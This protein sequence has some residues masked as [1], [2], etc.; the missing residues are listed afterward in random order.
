MKKFLIIIFAGV[1]NAGLVEFGP[2]NI[3]SNQEVLQNRKLIQRNARVRNEMRRFWNMYS[4]YNYPGLMNLQNLKSGKDTGTVTIGVLALRVEFQKETPDDPLTTGDGT[5]NLEGNGK[6]RVLEICNGDTIYNPYYDPPHDW[7]YF[8]RQMEAMADYYYVATF[9]KVR[10][11]WVVKPDSG[12]PPIKLAHPMRYYGDTINMATGLVAFVRDAFIAADIQDSSI[13]FNDLD[14]DGIK[15]ANEGV[16]DRYIIF[17]AG[18]AWQT[19]VLWDTPFDLAAVTIP[20][21]AL[22]YYLGTPFIVLNEGQDT[23]YDACMLP[24][25]M[26]Q[27]GSEIKLQGT[28]IHES[29][30]NLFFLPDLYDTYMQ[31]SGIGSFG[32]MTTAPYLGVGDQIPEGLIV[33]LPNAWERI[34]MDWFMNYVFGRGFLNSSIVQ[35][36]NAGPYSQN[37]EIKTKNI[38]VDSIGLGRN[39]NLFYPTGLT[40]EENPYSSVRYFKIPINDH[41]YFLVEDEISDLPGDDTTFVC[42]GDT[43]DVHIRGKYKDGVVVHFY[44][45]NDFLIGGAPGESKGLLIWHI[46]DDIIWR[47][48]GLNEVNAHRP[49][50]V[51]LLEADH[52][53]DFERWTENGYY[54]YTWFGSPYD[55]YFEGNNTEVS[56]TSH[57]SS[58][59]NA[60]AST[61]I[62]IYDISTADTV[63]TFKLERELSGISARIGYSGSENFANI[64]FE[65]FLNYV[66]D[67]LVVTQNIYSYTID[68][69]TFDSTLIDSFSVISIVNDS[70]SVV[71]ADTLRRV[72]KF[73][74]EPAV[75][76]LNNDS[77][78]EIVAATDAGW[79]YFFSINGGLNLMRP[80]VKLP[81]FITGPPAI[82]KIGG[83]DYVF[84]G[85]DDQHLYKISADSG[86]VGSI[87]TAS[88]QYATPVILDDDST[89]II[90][91]ADGRLLFTDTSFSEIDTAIFSPQVVPTRVLPAYVD[92]DRDSVREIVTVTSS[93]MA[94]VVNPYE[95]RV[96]EQAPFDDSLVT[97]TAVG[98]INADGYPDIVFGTYNYVYAFNHLGALIDGYPV[99]ISGTKSQP[100]IGDANG[101]GVPDV[102]VGVSGKGVFAFDGHGHLIPGFPIQIVDSL[103]MS[104]LLKPSGSRFA[105]FYISNGGFL[106]GWEIGDTTGQW[107]QYG[108]S[109]SHDGHFRSVVH[110]AGGGAGEF[111]V[112][113]IYFYPNPTYDGLTRLRL[114]VSQNTDVTLDVF[115][116]SGHILKSF[117]FK[118]IN[119]SGFEER[120]LDL[121]DL[122][123]GVYYV[124][125][126][127]SKTGK[128]RLVKLAIVR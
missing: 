95:K 25:T 22:E 47:Y 27:D 120:T 12:L 103:S 49:M 31:G 43:W 97:S 74:F 121:R 116:F 3:I 81:S 117:T 112:E 111:K 94:Y 48:W 79:V 39:G 6:P 53:Q 30:H 93:G 124:R 55:L 118:D 42:N 32:I 115:N 108:N 18:S 52:V 19:D 122:P 98:D 21:G 91:S 2:Q 119:P 24:E 8:N 100:V 34:W 40:F 17:H 45:E 51:D 36:V 10:I 101:D 11:E 70:G 23:V 113:R 83:K 46:D 63:M 59:D 1:L 61:K 75:G 99:K 80:P 68:P 104:M 123:P 90:Q 109:P 82:L 85:C 106:N 89:V 128:T 88:A 50:G 26:S 44:G 15:D 33:P 58:R 126:K 62:K 86:V 96:E 84:I 16:W 57:P 87:Y 65:S 77:I 56:D 105:L 92:I 110:P 107:T 127:F 28:L 41:E 73:V 37:H 76:D 13:H 54:A 71:Q 78:P 114:K 102:I 67:S 9:G 38:L 69:L 64:P 125:V 60:D 66:E 29:G 7:V 5:F 4:L 35:T 14:N 20:A 72:G